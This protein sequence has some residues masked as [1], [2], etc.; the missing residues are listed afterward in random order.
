[1]TSREIILANLAHQ[2]P[3][4][5]GF[6]F[7]QPGRKNDIFGTGLGSSET[8]EPMRKLVGDMEYYDDEWGN[9]WR[10]K[11]DGCAG[12]EVCEPALKDWKQ[13]DS[14][15]L[16]D[17]DNPKRYESVRAEFAKAGDMFRLASMPGWVFSTS[18]YLRK[19]EVYFVDLVEYREEIDRLHDR[20]T[21][22]YLKMIRLY[23]QN[24]AEGIAFCEDLG[25]QDRTL[26]SPSMWREIFRPHYLKLTGA[27]HECGL[28]VFMHSCGFNWA[29]ID[30]LATAGIDCLQFDQ[31]TLYDLPA[32][33]E[34]FRRHK[35]AL[36]S[37][38][39][40]QKVL[41]TGN[42]A[43]I[44]SEAKRMVDTFRGF[45]ICKNY[46]DLQGIGVKPEWDRW[47]Y[48]ALLRAAGVSET[49]K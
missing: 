34:K 16:P 32:L 6:C 35:V 10:R 22:L 14:M 30:D 8:Y 37:P 11:V 28:K 39:D 13:L 4:R 7:S 15:K 27:A 20:V 23:A 36:F 2:N 44:E 48:D 38:V 19:M 17:Y 21:E 47:A 12:G 9:L 24:G 1:M 42:R 25:V 31:P 29:L 18:R 3:D 33:A 46:G 45:L 43:F 49:Q 40:I 5:P 41:P 26:V